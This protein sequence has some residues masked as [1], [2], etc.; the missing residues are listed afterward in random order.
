MIDI[1]NILSIMLVRDTLN[2]VAGNI[3]NNYSDK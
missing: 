1:N 3:D 2:E